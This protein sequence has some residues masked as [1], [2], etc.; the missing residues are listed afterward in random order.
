MRSQKVKVNKKKTSDDK[1]GVFSLH[2][3]INQECVETISACDFYY[4]SFNPKTGEVRKNK[5]DWVRALAMIS[6]ISSKDNKTKNIGSRLFK[7]IKEDYNPLLEKL[8]EINVVIC[9]TSP[10]VGSD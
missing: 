1:S 7:D 4:K 3:Q 2:L 5:N 8:I 6:L 9:H 10:S